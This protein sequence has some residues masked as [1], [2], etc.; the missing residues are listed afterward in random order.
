MVAPEFVD[1]CKTLYGDLID[2]Q[3]IWED[4]LKAGP[5]SADVHVKSGTRAKLERASNAL[6]LTAAA[7]ATGSALRDD[8]FSAESGA[9]KVAQRLH[10]VGSAI[11]NPI[12]SRKGRVGAVLA[13]GALL[14]QGA[15]AAGDVAIGNSMANR[16]K[17]KKSKGKLVPVHKSAASVSAE[18]MSGA[19]R[20]KRGLLQ[21]WNPPTKAVNAARPAAAKPTYVARPNPS[22]NDIKATKHIAQGAD[23]ANMLNTTSGK[24][25]AGSVAAAGGVKAK[26]LV[27]P[28]S[29]SMSYVPDDMAKGIPDIEW[30]GTFSKFDEDKHLA[31]GWASV[32]S[33][34]GVPV[35]DKQGDYIAIED[36]EDAAYSY[37]KKSRVGGDNHT[38]NG[39]I[40][41]KVSDLVES[42]VFTDD[43]VAKMGLPDDF[44]RGWWVGFKVHDD[45]V[46]SEVRKG[47]RTGFSIH[48]R[49]IRSEQSVDEL[50]G[51]TK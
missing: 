5:D 14:T 46:W 49:G 39:A 40:A 13:G 28:K 43:K 10:R 31:F 47:N 45:S 37:V 20:S 33:K 29:S 44:P 11:P 24:V 30:K 48:G 38:R 21:I 41:H 50:M 42:M 7:M 19:H 1:L 2:P 34:G 26:G 3:V 17:K 25:L 9:G 8:R 6:G 22:A 4:V 32:V 12:S 36:I 18:V 16:E 35:I 27:K 23:V 51:Y 15:N